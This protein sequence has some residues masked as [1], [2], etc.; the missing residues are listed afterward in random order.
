MNRLTKCYDRVPEF[1]GHEE[2]NNPCQQETR[3]NVDPPSS[4]KKD[5]AYFSSP[6]WNRIFPFPQETVS[7]PVSLSKIGENRPSIVGNLPADQNQEVGLSRT[8]TP[9]SCELKKL[10]EWMLDFL[11]HSS[12]TEILQLSK[13]ITSLISHFK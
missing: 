6:R 7:H 8:D 1:I 12:T 2:F 11:P 5:N 9:H 13:E 10:V 3:T 4:S